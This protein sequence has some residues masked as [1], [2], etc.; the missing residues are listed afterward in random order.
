[1]VF[2]FFSQGMVRKKIFFRQ[3]F[4]SQQY[5]INTK[6]T[7]IFPYSHLFLIRPVRVRGYIRLV[8]NKTI[9]RL[10][11]KILELKSNVT[12]N[13]TYLGFKINLVQ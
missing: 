7:Y 3:K 9:L 13:L 10:F 1:M 2:V 6:E 11:V 12:I 5:T 8:L 4:K